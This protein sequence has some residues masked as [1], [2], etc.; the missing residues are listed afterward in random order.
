M[1]P[2]FNVLDLCFF[3]SLQTL[4][5][6]KLATTFEELR[7]NVFVAFREYETAKLSDIWITMQLIYNKV[8]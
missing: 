1:S 6:C 5:L 4:Q 3:N 2:D 7:Y 8:I